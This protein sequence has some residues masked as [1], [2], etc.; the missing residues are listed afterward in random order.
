MSRELKELS[1]DT[2][3]RMLESKDRQWYL[4]RL[5]PDAETLVKY[6]TKYR[7]EKHDIMDKLVQKNKTAVFDKIMEHYFNEDTEQN[8]ELRRQF[9]TSCAKNG[10]PKDFHYFTPYFPPSYKQKIQAMLTPNEQ[11]RQRILQA[12]TPPYTLT[13]ETTEKLVLYRHI[14]TAYTAAIPK[15][16]PYHGKVA[17]KQN[18]DS[19]T[20][21]ETY[22]CIRL[23]KIP[24]DQKKDDPQ[25]FQTFD[26]MPK[27]NPAQLNLARQVFNSMHFPEFWIDSEWDKG[28]GYFNFLNEFDKTC[29]HL[30]ENNTPS[31]TLLKKFEQDGHFLAL[32][33]IIN[34]NHNGNSKPGVEYAGF[35]GETYIGFRCDIPYKE[36]YLIHEL[37]HN[38]GDFENTDIYHFI[39]IPLDIQKEKSTARFRAVNESIELYPQTEFASE[40]LAR[41]TQTKENDPDYPSDP[42]LDA[43]RKLFFT[44]SKAKTKKQNGIINR[45]NLCARNRIAAFE[46]FEQAY[47]NLNQLHTTQETPNST[48]EKINADNTKFSKSYDK[49]EDTYRQKGETDVTTDTIENHLIQCIEKEIKAIEEINKNELADK[50]VLDAETL[51]RDNLEDETPL[52][53]LIAKTIRKTQRIYITKCKEQSAEDLLSNINAFTTIAKQNLDTIEQDQKQNRRLDREYYLESVGNFCKSLMFIDALIQKY[54][55]KHNTD[56]DCVDI[57]IPTK[58]NMQNI[59]AVIENFKLLNSSNEDI[60]ITN[61]YMEQPFLPIKEY[62]DAGEWIYNSAGPEDKHLHFQKLN[63]ILKKLCHANPK[64]DPKEEIQNLRLLQLI[65]RELNPSATKLPKELRF[66]NLTYKDFEP[67]ED[68]SIVALSELPQTEKDRKKEENRKQQQEEKL[69]ELKDKISKRKYKKI[70]KLFKDSNNYMPKPNE[71]ISPCT[72]AIRFY[73]RRLINSEHFAQMTL[74]TAG[75]IQPKSR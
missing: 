1:A 24:K 56:E 27:Y 29:H 74:Q 51:S 63:R 3:I 32:E 66:E 26:I 47:Q 57:Y 58:R 36:E 40:S 67:I 12:E 23:I 22:P 34:I 64:G 68:K 8:K 41:V 65:Y 70:K 71:E 4:F 52:E 31:N 20:N 10:K 45:I 18:L 60:K 73:A 15:I 49:I 28:L 38:I 19:D 59:D 61:Q 69:K 53:V 44:F 43:T 21:S 25:L 14:Y 42:L 5:I 75:K 17:K 7:D 30:R 55:P 39:T 33:N 13:P 54:N 35:A 16:Y 2:F 62:I 6:V 9:I 11:T 37:A 46:L 50:I 48:A 72:K